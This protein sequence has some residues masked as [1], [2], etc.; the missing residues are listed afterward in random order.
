TGARPD[1][2]TELYMRVLDAGLE[3]DPTPLAEI[4]VRM[5]QGEVAHRRWTLF[6]QS[7]IPKIV[8]YGLAGEKD[9]LGILEQLRDELVPAQGFI[10]LSWLMIAQWARKPGVAVQSPERKQ[11]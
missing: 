9:V 11:K 2:G 4:A 3:P 5:G 6:A 8:E 7:F 1:V 10:P